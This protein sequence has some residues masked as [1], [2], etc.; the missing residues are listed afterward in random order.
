[1][2]AARPALA[3]LSAAA[4]LRPRMDAVTSLAHPPGAHGSHVLLD[5]TGFVAPAEESGEWM[6]ECL[7]ST[8]ASHGVR[9]VHSKLVVLGEDGESPPG[10]TAVCLLDESHVTAHCYSD[11]GLLA[12]DVFTCGPH[13]PQPIAAELRRHVEAHV[14]GSRCIM[15]QTVGRFHHNDG[16]QPASAELD[17][18]EQIGAGRLLTGLRRGERR[19]RQRANGA[20]MSAEADEEEEPAAAQEEDGEASDAM[21]DAMLG[22]FASRLQ[23]EG[24]ESGLRLRSGADRAGKEVREAS[25]RAGSALNK[26]FDL[27][28]S[29]PKPGMG[30]DG[31][32]LDTNSWKLTV[33]ILG[34]TL[35]L[36]VGTAL[37]TDFGDGSGDAQF[38][39]AELARPNEIMMFGRQ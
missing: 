38:T 6:L 30:G 1:M 39:S 27:D 3:L 17:S 2:F 9:A 23:D 21:A 32:M 14:V 5:F 31:G 8:V 13:S 22:A 37:T 29:A 36:A 16:M 20:R 15:E 11:R 34:A 7:T 25:E 28:G 4:S 26:A 12:I 24:G 10:F 19:S 35:V 33:G 18:G